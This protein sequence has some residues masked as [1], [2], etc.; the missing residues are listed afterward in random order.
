M[1][2]TLAIIQ[3]DV[4]GKRFIFWSAIVFSC[5]P[6]VLMVFP[7]FRSYPTMAVVA[8]VTA[9][10]F[11]LAVTIGLGTT[12]IGSD[13]SAGRL[14]FY[15]AKP[16]S[17]ASLWYGKLIAAL[18]IIYGSLAIV[19]TPV[20]L[21][22]ANRRGGEWAE[23]RNVIAIIAAIA[24][25]L[26]LVA[27]L[28]STV[29]RARSILLA[30]DAMALSMAVAGAWLI[31]RVLAPVATPALLQ[32][33][34]E[35]GAAALMVTLVTAGAWHLSRGRTDRRAN[36]VALSKFVWLSVAI[37]LAAAGGFAWW[38][39]GVPPAEITAAEAFAAPSGP[40]AVVTGESPRG[41]NQVAFLLNASD[42]TF[43]RIPG[44]DFQ[45]RTLF[46]RDGSTVV[47]SHLL[48]PGEAT[49]DLV[50]VNAPFE[51]YT[52]D[53]AHGG[54][55]LQTGIVTNVWTQMALSDNGRRL[56]TLSRGIATVTDVLSRMAVGSFR[57]GANGPTTTSMFFADRDALRLYVSAIGR[58]ET[59]V[60]D[61]S[62]RILE[63]DI[64]R[65]VLTETGS[66]RSRGRFL[67]FSV[68][69][70][71][72]YLIVRTSDPVEP[73]DTMFVADARTGARIMSVPRAQESRRGVQFDGQA[74]VE[75]RPSA[76][77][78]LT[79]RRTTFDQHVLNDIDLGTGAAGY[80]G[81][82][83][84]PRML[85]GVVEGERG[86]MRRWKCIVID[87]AHNAIVKVVPA[88]RPAYPQ[89]PFDSDPRVFIVATSVI[90]AIDASGHVVRI[91][92][93]TGEVTPP[94]R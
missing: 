46:S 62:V 8:N 53:L 69:P 91:D 82:V 15:F 44:S 90:A 7:M 61:L 83:A 42:G 12:M 30:V 13:L 49:G 70:R 55:F 31:L 25:V 33:V 57:V 6:F 41:K 26:L 2:T 19:A 85:L 23:L 34:C 39:V 43:F 16:V 4:A 58:D 22:A 59:A 5:I 71:G 45:S 29:F 27:H 64:Q 40:W 92:V 89:M 28:V 3:S 66:L 21:Y 80:V 87:T 65:R 14:S 38:L 9:V 76:N 48:R 73:A 81:G 51:V 11:I 86:K 24:P 67:S 37:V 72:D 74:I 93:A 77:G 1:R 52:R 32:I 10:T 75:V 88:V 20:A 17:A 47:W 50:P 78:H 35:S 84:G 94:P 56:A 63:Y 54:A 36:H 79:F 18:V 68:T 60:S